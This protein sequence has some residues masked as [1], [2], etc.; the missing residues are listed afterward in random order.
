[1][2]IVSFYLVNNSLKDRRYYDLFFL[3]MRT[4]RSRGLIHLV[5]ITWLDLVEWIF[6]VEI[7]SGCLTVLLKIQCLVF[8]EVSSDL[9]EDREIEVK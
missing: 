2:Y 5:Q 4:I 7:R 3:Q 9:L 1:M 8:K 6:E